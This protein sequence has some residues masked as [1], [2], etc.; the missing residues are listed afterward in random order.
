VLYLTESPF[1]AVMLI[2]IN[3]I[4]DTLAALALATA[5]PLERVIYEPAITENVSILQPVVWRQIYGIT[6]WNILVMS[7]VIFAGKSLFGL[8]YEASD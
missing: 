5:P 2:W 3:L 1:N 7:L 4:M 8:Q 6:V